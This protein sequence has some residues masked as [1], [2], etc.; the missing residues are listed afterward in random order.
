M[1]TK[2][3]VL[4]RAADHIQMSEEKDDEELK[5]PK[6]SD[7]SG[8]E[9]KTAAPP[10]AA[11]K[12]KTEVRR[13][14]K[15]FGHLHVLF[16]DF[17]FTGDEA[18]IYQQLLGKEKVTKVLKAEEQREAKAAQERNDIRQLLLDNF[19]SISIHLFKQPA[20]PDDLR[21]YKE[22]PDHLI[23]PAFSATVKELLMSVTQQLGTPTSFNGSNLTGSYQII[24]LLRLLHSM[25]I[26]NY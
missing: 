19:E 5:S 24:I 6:A 3:G 15:K 26:D 17:A 9:A 12:M 22:V 2:L 25:C 13:S 14:G 11:E 23:D 8:V 10:S 20:S 16:R 4:A 18:A 21:E 1:L 7:A